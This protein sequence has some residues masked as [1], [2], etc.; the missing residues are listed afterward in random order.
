MERIPVYFMPGLAASPIIFENIKLPEDKFEMFFL[1]W[2]LPE[3]GESLAHYAT[4]IAENILHENPV[5]IGVSFGGVLV[6]EIAEMITPRKVIIISSVKCN[7]EFPRRMR[8][9][10]LVKAYR[11]FP[12]ALMERVDWLARFAN[13]NSFI[14]KR[15]KLYEK[16]LSV[17]DKRYL[18]WAFKTIILWDRVEPNPRVIHIHGDAD[19]VFPPQYLSNYIP[20]KGGTHIMIINK[21]KWFNEN[22]PQI[23]TGK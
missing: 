15:L 1:E 23:I 4:R 6:Q 8:F 11:V 19:G 14:A 3:E 21:A 10:K 9:A 2:L 20:I 13:G 16:Y 12:T 22:L 5:L 7:T 17:R 18:D